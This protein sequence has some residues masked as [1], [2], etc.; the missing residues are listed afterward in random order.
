[1]GLD[2]VTLWYPGMS[3]GNQKVD[4]WHYAGRE[5]KLIAAVV[6][7]SGSVGVKVAGMSRVPGFEP[8]SELPEDVIEDLISDERTYIED[9]YFQLVW[10]DSGGREE[11][12]CDWHPMYNLDLALSDARDLAD[13]VR[14]EPSVIWEKEMAKALAMEAQDD[15]Q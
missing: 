8:G 14:L 12:D 4:A 3:E 5:G 10:L 11:R 6:G 15:A 1:M 2:T 13:G 9:C 7:K